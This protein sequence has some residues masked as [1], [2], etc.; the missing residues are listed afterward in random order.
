MIN[1]NDVSIKPRR[2][3]IASRSE[4]NIFR[5]FGSKPKNGMMNFHRPVCPVIVANMD[6]CGT[7]AMAKAL[8][9]Y[10]IMTALHKYYSVEKLAEWYKNEIESQ[11]TFYSMGISDDD[12]AKFEAVRTMAGTQFEKQV[13][14]DVANGYMTKFLDFIKRFKEKYPDVFV[15]AGNV[16]TPEGCED[17]IEAGAN[18]VVCG[19]GN[20]SLCLTSNKAGIGV[21]QLKVILD[22]AP[23][24]RD[25]NAYMVSD[26]GIRSPA[27][28]CKA[29]VAGADFVMIGGLF[30]GYE[31]NEG[32][33]KYDTSRMT[34]TALKCYGM[35]S[36]TAN[37]KYNGGMKEYRTSEGREEWIPYK[38]PVAQIAQ[39]IHGSIASCGAYTNCKNVEEFKNLELVRISS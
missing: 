28:I 12:L 8:Y 23:V 32:Q 25:L 2:S 13:R 18:G 36:K 6:T 11:L 31:E 4:V 27:D 33:W 3:D 37:D 39:D 22:C 17:I 16:C 1:F 24:C 20:G 15:L 35:S 9:P 10:R 30:M 38:G 7:M 21:P 26:G 14:I 29:L 34:K 5:A 19:I